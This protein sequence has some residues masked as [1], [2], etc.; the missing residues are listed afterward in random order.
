MF[1][2]GQM[3]Q[4]AIVIG[5]LSFPAHPWQCWLFIV[6]FCGGGVVLNTFGAKSLATLELF[7]ATAFVLGYLAN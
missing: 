2:T 4:Y 5:E 7:I 6:A 3:A 1:I